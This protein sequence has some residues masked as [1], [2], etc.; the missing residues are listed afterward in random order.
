V[1]F[2]L[3][4]TFT[5]AVWLLTLPHGLLTRTQYDAVSLSAD[6]VKFADVVA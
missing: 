4:E 5:V 2:A 1:G 6:V 3:A